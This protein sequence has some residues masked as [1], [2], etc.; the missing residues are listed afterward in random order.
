MLQQAAKTPPPLETLS[1]P[2]SDQPLT[3]AVKVSC[4]VRLADPDRRSDMLPRTQIRR[5]ELVTVE[6]TPREIAAIA[7]LGAETGIAAIETGE[8]L[9]L[10]HPVVTPR[11][12]TEPPSRVPKSVL[13][14]GSV[15]PDRSHRARRS[16]RDRRRRRLRFRAPGLPDDRRNTEDPLRE[17]L[18]PGRA[19]GIA[20]GAAAGAIQRRRGNHRRANE[21]RARMEPHA[22]GGRHG[23]AAPVVAASRRA[24]AR[25]WRASLP[26]AR[27]S[28]RK[29]RSR[30]S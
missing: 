30:A 10:P 6:L 11:A 19:E 22:Q 24:R 4:F 2:P 14:A 15:V 28:V 26:A 17:H 29:P 18:G 23:S 25:T 3:D 12:V 20:A 27:A 9:A 7:D 5:G 8:P 1:A 21:P 16:H 13:T